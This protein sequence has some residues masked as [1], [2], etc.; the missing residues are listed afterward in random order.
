MQN[1]FLLNG[2][3]RRRYCRYFEESVANRFL[4]L[5]FVFFVGWAKLILN[6]NVKSQ[7]NRSL[8]RQSAHSSKSSFA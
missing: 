2:K 3:A 1:L 7:N 4:D 6:G 5:E 8:F